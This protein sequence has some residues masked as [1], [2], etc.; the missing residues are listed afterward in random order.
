MLTDGQ[1]KELKEALLSSERPIIFFHDD[2][3]GVGS[4]LQF[5][6]PIGRG[7]GITVKST[8]RVDNRFI[9]T[10]K[11]YGPDKIFILDL[12]LVDQEFVD[13]M[14]VPI[15]WLD[16]HDRQDI[17]DEAIKGVKYY[18]PKQ[19]I[20]GDNTCIAKLS[21]DIFGEHLWIAAAGTIGDWQLPDDLR[22]EILNKMPELFSDK[23]KK[24]DEALFTTK[25]GELSKIFNFVLK[26]QMK[27]VNQ[28]FKILTRIN[29]PKEL[30]EEN[31]EQGKYLMKR[32]HHVNKEY[33][34]LLKRAEKC[35]KKKDP[36]L[37]FVYEENKISLSG[38]ISNEL[39]FKY[40]EKI[41]IV[42]RHHNGEMKTSFRWSKN[43]KD[44]LERA[45]EGIEGRVGGHPNACGGLIKDYDWDK[46]ITNLRGLL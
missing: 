3:D 1:K 17:G 4:F 2:A 46:F 9:D 43:I 39:L 29:D 19:N 42:A 10:V 44:M 31:S 25:I 30:L 38:E 32:Y 15:Y 28:A 7:K 6:K 14:N 23:V 34:E 22:K 18:N 12:A 8:P 33:T 11:N 35:M 20:E 21:Y 5:Y 27:D 37:I 13:A 41:I 40:P 16:H 45:V 36:L 24:P 26:G